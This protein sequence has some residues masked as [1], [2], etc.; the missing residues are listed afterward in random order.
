MSEID[1]KRNIKN[2]EVSNKS[3]Y[4]IFPMLGGRREDYPYTR[5]VFISAEEFLDL[6]NRLFLLARKEEKDK[7]FKFYIN[8]LKAHSMYERHYEPD[9]HHIMFVFKILEEQK[10][11]FNLFKEGKYSHFSEDYKQSIRR[12]NGAK[13]GEWG[14]NLIMVLNKDP[15]LRKRWEEYLSTADD[16]T[17]LSPV[18][19]PENIDLADKPDYREIYSEDM[20]VKVNKPNID[21]IGD[22]E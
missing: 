6:D 12:F 11:N 13:L 15:E 18:K 22:G 9:N 14:H 17:P 4:M 3:L 21:L 7:L 8:M 1:R 10:K 2:A 5:G 19:I 16:G 20:K